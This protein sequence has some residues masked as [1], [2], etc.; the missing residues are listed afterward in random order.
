M[1]KTRIKTTKKLVLSG[2]GVEKLILN[3][4]RK[5]YLDVPKNASVNI[6]DLYSF[7]LHVTISWD[8]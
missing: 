4:N 5:E 8:V 6:M 7:G 1:E 2:E 3:S